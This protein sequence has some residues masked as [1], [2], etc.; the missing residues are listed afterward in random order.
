MPRAE[1]ARAASSSVPDKYEQ[2]ACRLAAESCKA[3][4]ISLECAASYRRP[5]LEDW[6]IGCRMIRADVVAGPNSH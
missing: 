1:R 5:S 6:V 3:E 2:L 4:A